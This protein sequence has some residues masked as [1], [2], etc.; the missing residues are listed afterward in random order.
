[1]Y[2]E[3]ILVYRITIKIWGHGSIASYVQ[4]HFL[5]IKGLTISIRMT[6]IE[7]TLEFMQNGTKI[8]IMISN[9]QCTLMK[10]RELPCLI[11]RTSRN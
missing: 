2:L 6:V 10:S 8:R 9:N 5:G 3:I 4:K 11:T 1:M 7:S